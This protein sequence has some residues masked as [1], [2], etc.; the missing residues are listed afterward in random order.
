MPSLRIAALREV[1]INN[2]GLVFPSPQPKSY[3]TIPVNLSTSLRGTD[4]VPTDHAKMFTSTPTKSVATNS[5]LELE[6]STN[7]ESYIDASSSIVIDMN[8]SFSKSEDE[9]EDADFI[10]MDTMIIEQYQIMPERLWE[11]R[12][13]CNIYIKEH[14]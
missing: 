9:D 14:V 2:I 6:E 12:Y 5:L 10:S 8:M 11:Y 3:D 13:L 4:N 1:G 7:A